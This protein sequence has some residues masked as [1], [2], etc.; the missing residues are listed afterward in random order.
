MKMLKRNS[1]VALMVAVL[2]SVSSMVGCEKPVA[3]AGA[4]SAPNSNAAQSSTEV[5]SA[6]ENGERE[7][8]P[9]MNLKKPENSV[10][11]ATFN[12]ALNRKSAGELLTELESGSSAKIEKIAEIIQRVAPD[13]ILL[14]EVD[15]DGGKSAQALHDNFLTKPQGGQTAIEY[16]YVYVR[17]VN[18]G[19]DSEIDLNGDGKTG[20]P[21]DAFGYGVFP[22]QYAMV[23]FSKYEIDIDNARTFQKFLWKDM[24]DAMLPVDP[25]TS[26]SFYS[27]AALDVFR[28]SSK[29]HWDLPIRVGDKTIHL[30]ACHPTPPVFDGDEDRNGCR[31]HDE[32][33]FWS[34][35]VSGTADYVVDDQGRKGGLSADLFV[36][37]GDLNA[38]PNDGDSTGNPAKMLLGNANVNGMI[39]PQ[40]S[41]GKMFAREQGGANANHKGDPSCDTSDFND[42]RVGNMRI[43]YVLPSNTLTVVGQGVFWPKPDEE[44]GNLPE[45]SDHR[46]VWIDIEK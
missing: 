35:Y 4:S 34:D 12:V 43:D 23:V 39:V 30:L 32:I 45:A 18:T 17:G 25:A 13:V 40:S 33:R 19:V 1:G 21:E 6:N 11:F 38:D 8:G 24:P 16:P 9:A 20:T 14:N 22:G 5:T 41:G 26:D 3:P 28:L 7:D 2:I 46:L 44:G 42:A 37:A 36:I 27:D 15:F 31:N 10:R 29:S